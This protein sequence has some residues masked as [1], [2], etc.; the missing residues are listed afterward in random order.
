MYPSARFRAQRNHSGRRLEITDPWLKVL[1]AEARPVEYR[2]TRQRGLVL[3]VEPSGRRTWVARY[4]FAGRDRRFKLGTYPE[5]SLAKARRRAHAALA[6]AEAGT[7]PQAER[8]KLRAG[9]TIEA[10]VASWLSD[11]KLGPGAKW[12]GGLSGG[13]ARS[14]MP[15][16]NRLVRD[17]GTKRLV[18]LTSKDV[19]RFVSAPEAAAT[20][21]R[22]LT[23][24]RLFVAWAKRKGLVQ[25]DPSAQLGKEREQ[26]RSRTLSDA[27]LR[28]LVLGF[29]STRYGRAVRLLALTGLRRDE[30]LG[31]EWEWLDSEAAVLTIPPA[32]EKTGATRGEP[33][34]V[35]LS[36]QAVALLAEQRRAQL[37]EGARSVWIFGTR[38]G[39]RPHPDALKATINV[40]RGR[41]SNGLPASEDKR[42]KRREAVLPEDV[43]VHDVRRTVADALLNRLKV[44][45]WIV[46]HVVLGHARPKLLRT[47]M[48]TLPLDEARDALTR[49]AELLERILAAKPA[50]K[51]ETVR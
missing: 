29:D 43:T 27:E 11:E 41:R 19:E 30:A 40:L 25:A 5:T 13:S 9:E 32:A 35:A 47:Y 1:Q 21:N 37:S 33:R 17:L 45:P 10:A 31:A 14:F 7:D 23:T 46:D 12:K 6:Q 51:Q 36:P 22:A 18:E 28:A 26:E 50:E 2:D 3:R 20:R 39:G 8:E 15:H 16:V 24:W 48:P 44:A 42:A 4:S 38:T 34:H 49:W